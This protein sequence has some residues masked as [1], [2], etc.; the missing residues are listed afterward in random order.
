MAE[1]ERLPDTSD[2]SESEVEVSGRDECNTESAVPTNRKI[3]DDR[4]ITKIESNPF[5]IILTLFRN[6]A[7]NLRVPTWGSLKR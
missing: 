1:Y 2:L 5:V 6:H 4:I 3:N 7:Q